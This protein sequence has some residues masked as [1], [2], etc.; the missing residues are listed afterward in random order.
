M[1]SIFLLKLGNI[2]IKTI[3][4][5]CPKWWLHKPLAL[6]LSHTGWT[7]SPAMKWWDLN[8]PQLQVLLAKWHTLYAV[9]SPGNSWTAR[10]E[11]MPEYRAMLQDGRCDYGNGATAWSMELTTPHPLWKEAWGKGEGNWEMTKEKREKT[12]NFGFVPSFCDVYSFPFF[13]L[14]SPAG[15]GLRNINL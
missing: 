5:R 10:N 6:A 14:A 15:E 8:M 9:V 2:L 1:R 13:H 12:L 3:L 7:M 4:C 11:G